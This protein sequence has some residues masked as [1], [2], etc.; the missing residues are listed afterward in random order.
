MS[1]QEAEELGIDPLAR[2]RFVYYTN[3]KANYL[4]PMD[5]RD[6]FTLASVSIG[7][8]NDEYPDG[9]SVGV[10][11]P[12]SR[13]LAASEEQAEVALRALR[14]ASEEQRRK[15]QQAGPAWAGEVVRN[16]LGLPQDEA[17]TRRA[18]AILKQLLAEKRI[19]EVKAMDDQR[20]ERPVYEAV[21][22]AELEQPD[23]GDED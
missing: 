6:W 19:K 2:R 14:G 18:K 23:E 21:T 16:A 9:D 7:N 11:R 12:W 1:K 13:P 5:S 4:P 3:A 22:G 10:V 8:G 17:G 15:A 20:R